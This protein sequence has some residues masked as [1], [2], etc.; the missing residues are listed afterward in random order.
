MRS[1]WSQSGTRLPNLGSEFSGALSSALVAIPQSVVVGMLAVVPLGPSYAY[2]G[3]LAGLYASIISSFITALPRSGTCQVGGPH[4]SLSIITASVIAG[5]MADPRL[6][7]PDGPDIARILGLV[8]MCLLLAGLFQTLLG[9]LRF[10]NFVKYIPYPVVAGFMNGIAVSVFLAQLHPLLG[11]PAT[12]MWSDGAGAWWDAFKPYGLLIGMLTLLFIRMSLGFVKFIPPILTGLILG[13]L[14]YYLAR[15]LLGEPAVGGT[16]GDIPSRLPGPEQLQ[17]FLA[18]SW[19]R[20]FIPLAVELVPSALLI[21]VV[22]SIVSLMN[23]VSLASLTRTRPNNNTELLMQGLSNMANAAFGLA[24][25]AGAGSCSIANYKAGG[26]TRVSTMIHAILLLAAVT[27]LAYV[28]WAGYIPAV[29]MAALLV[30]NAFSAIDGWSSEILKR[31]R[32]PVHSR[33]DMLTNL[34]VVGIVTTVMVVFNLT[35]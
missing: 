34:L 5:L 23:S 13:T 17:R 7:G 19:D 16:I 11:V 31:L 33:Q 24:P 21:A 3:V 28:P 25:S 9:A 35:A 29:V 8:F 22:S 30:D 26:R 18:I 14:T 12:V 10:G 4:S 27:S 1:P 20:S 32:G 15:S 6:A 2:L